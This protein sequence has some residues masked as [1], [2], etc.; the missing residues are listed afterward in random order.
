MM[1]KFTLYENGYPVTESTFVLD[2]IVRMNLRG[3]AIHGQLASG[4][5]DTVMQCGSYHLNIDGYAFSIVRK[6]DKHVIRSVP[7]HS[8]LR[9]PLNNMIRVLTWTIPLFAILWILK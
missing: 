7:V 6:M 5:I 3:A 2:L 1:N 8:D 9:G 4:I